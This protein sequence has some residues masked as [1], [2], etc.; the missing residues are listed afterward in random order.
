VVSTDVISHSVGLKLTINVFI[1][2]DLTIDDL[3][4][5]EFII[6]NLTI[7]EFD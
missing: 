7:N 5:N 3:T 4:I 1:I 6:D 2:D